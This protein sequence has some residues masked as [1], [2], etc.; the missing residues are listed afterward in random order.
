MGYH[1]E[2]KQ[3]GSPAPSKNFRSNINL[4][5]HLVITLQ[6]YLPLQIAVSVE[7]GHKKGWFSN[8]DVRSIGLIPE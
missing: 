8:I 1:G 7:F 6:W 2:I 5:K 4:G 3:F